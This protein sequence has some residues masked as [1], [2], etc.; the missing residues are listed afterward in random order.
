M[1]S[2]EPKNKDKPVKDENA[3]HP[4]ADEWRPTI[5]RV[6]KQLA[7]GDY[8]L[9]RDQGADVQISEASAKQIQAYIDQY[10][11]SLVD[12]P[13]ETWSTSVAQWM[14]SHWDLLVDLWTSES[15]RSDLVLAARVYEKNDIYR[16]VIDS[17]YVP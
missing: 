13:D 5:R 7:R 12:L 17:V 9:A 1:D 16:F 2:E 3:A 15:G 4:I 6:V 8:S 14:G 10:G 11:E